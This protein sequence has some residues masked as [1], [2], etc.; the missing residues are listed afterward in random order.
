MKTSS[1][2]GFLLISTIVMI[3]MIAFF[4]G[5]VLYV[6]SGSSRAGVSYTLSK[7]ALYIAEAGMQRAL[8]ALTTTSVDDPTELVACTNLATHPHFNQVN[9]GGGQFQVNGTYYNRSSTLQVALGAGNLIVLN[10]NDAATFAPQ[11]RVFIGDEE[12]DYSGIIGSTSLAIAKRG[13][14]GTPITTHPIGSTVTQDL[15]YVRSTGAVPNFV[16]PI[17]QRQVTQSVYWPNF[18]ELGWTF[19]PPSGL[20]RWDGTAWIDV[21]NPANPSTINDIEMLGPNDGWLVSNALPGGTPGVFRWN[22]SSWYAANAGL[23]SETG[24]NIIGVTATSSD[25]VWIVGNKTDTVKNKGITTNTV[26]TKFFQWSQVLSNW[27]WVA[28]GTFSVNNTGSTPPLVNAKDLQVV[29]KDDGSYFGLAVG[30]GGKTYRCTGTCANWNEITAPGVASELSSVFVFK[31][32]A[33]ALSP[34]TTGTGLIYQ[35]NGTA[36]VNA[37]PTIIPAASLPTNLYTLD[38]LDTDNNGYADY[39]FAG[40]NGGHVSY[41]INGV[42][43]NEH[44]IGGD[45]NGVAAVAPDDLW[46][47]GQG[48]NRLSYWDGN[49]SFDWCDTQAPNSAVCHN[50]KLSQIKMS[51]MDAEMRKKKIGMWFEPVN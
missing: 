23:G 2:K 50:L 29:K 42:W 7:R 32:E 11:G 41:L 15:C 44:I 46:F 47:I 49:Q 20:L 28:D 17:A 26:T 30:E 12:I 6:Y 35:W 21:P 3:V 34:A 31:N 25:H 14:G 43:T 19:G 16:N 9:F 10:S 45:I 1:Q 13:A 4:T 33:W 38:L 40:G 24:L 8:Y 37:V 22:G 51:G 48:D 27:Q 36:W 5:I 18:R 39:G